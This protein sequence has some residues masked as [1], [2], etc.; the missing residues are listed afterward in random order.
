MNFNYVLGNLLDQSKVWWQVFVE[1]IPNLVVA[2]VIII[3]F[4]I[5]GKIVKKVI[6]RG[7][8]ETQTRAGVVQL[9][10]SAA[11]VT[12]L[13]IGILLALNIMGL[14]RVVTSVL[15]GVG[16]VGLALGFAFQDIAANLISGISLAFSDY[17]EVGDVISIDGQ[18]G[19]VIKTDLRA[20]TISLPT[21]GLFVVPNRYIFTNS[22]VNI[23][24]S[25]NRGVELELSV[26]YDT[27]LDL[28]EGYILNALSK[29]SA[30]QEKDVIKIGLNSFG[31]SGINIDINFIVPVDTYEQFLIARSEAIKEIKKEL[32]KQGVVIPYQTITLDK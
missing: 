21:G 14:D 1:A 2:I 5:I 9:L 31:A 18:T 15:A 27:N 12:I 13:A 29:V 19:T 28:V 22:F 17:A 26:G 25:G 30:I 6:K 16:L 3:I 20:T 8:K 7:G 32:D 10:G 23:S 24:D 4:L 11:K